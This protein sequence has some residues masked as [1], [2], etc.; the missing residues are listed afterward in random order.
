ML[1]YLT[2]GGHEVRSRLLCASGV[3]VSLS[4]YLPSINY[5]LASSFGYHYSGSVTAGIMY[6]FALASIVTSSVTMRF[7]KNWT[8]GVVLTIFSLCGIFSVWLINHLIEYGSGAGFSDYD[9]KRLAF[10]FYGILLV[11]VLGAFGSGGASDFLRG[12][13]RCSAISSLALALAYLPLYDP[14]AGLSRVG[15]DAG[16][17]V[18][19]LLSQ[20][21]TSVLAMIWLKW[22][23]SRLGFLFL[24]VLLSAMV[25]SGTRSALSVAVFTMILF[26]F[27]QL[28][29]QSGRVLVYYVG[30][31]CFFVVLLIFSI[32]LIPDNTLERITRFNLEG[33]EDRSALLVAAWKI[34][35]DNPFG[36]TI[37]F[38]GLFPAEI[39]YSHNTAIQVLVEAGVIVLPLLL[40]LFY[41]VVRSF[42]LGR[43]SGE[44]IR[45]FSLYAIGVYLTSFSAGDAYYPQ[46]WLVTAFLAAN[47]LCFSRDKRTASQVVLRSS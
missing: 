13:L 9:N 2:L 39:E 1:G 28:V 31:L 35:L 22:F 26:F 6:S 17:L 38:V 8:L 18:G 25:M 47:G 37:G 30:L 10:A 21:V 19:V 16:L 15:G 29:S 41:G 40:L 14:N 27:R 36:K 46:F 23:D 5:C 20:G 33:S 7:R 24:P 12:F 45:G 44:I 34:F 3:L 43:N 11:G 42:L 4:F 32:D